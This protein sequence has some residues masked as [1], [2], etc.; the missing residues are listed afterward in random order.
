M[1]V[2]LEARSSQD[3]SAAGRVGGDPAAALH[4]SA[5][6]CRISAAR[7]SG[8]GSAVAHAM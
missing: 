5:S 4:Q 3:R 2:D 6:A 8:C 7:R 1:L